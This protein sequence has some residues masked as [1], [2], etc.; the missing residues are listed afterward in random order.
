MKTIIVIIAC[1]ALVALGYLL[2]LKSGK[3]DPGP[4]KPPT[5]PSPSGGDGKTTDGKK[6]P[7][8]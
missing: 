6:V 7:Q 8:E 2:V 4:S 3:T 5:G 1:A